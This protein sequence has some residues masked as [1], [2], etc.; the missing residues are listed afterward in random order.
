MQQP[1]TA[2]WPSASK[3]FRFADLPTRRNPNGS[4]SRD[5]GHGALATGEHV[6]LHESIQPPGIPP[7]PAHRINHTELICIREGTLEFLHDNRTERAEAGDVI[8]VANG[9]L[10]RVRNV[11]NRP[12]SYFV[13]AIGGDVD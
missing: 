8:L 11:G 10:H 12:A 6:A 1:T 5:I 3:V 4:E 2:A 7:N 13:V 9:T